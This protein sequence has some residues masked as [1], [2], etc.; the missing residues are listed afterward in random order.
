MAPPP[1]QKHVGK[2]RPENFG[3]EFINAFNFAQSDLVWNQTEIKDHH[4]CLSTVKD[5][6]L[7]K[8]N[9]DI[10]NNQQNVNY[11]ITV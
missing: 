9:T 10:N 7:V 4:F 8:K 11:W 2:E 1:M 5:N 3:T 6:H